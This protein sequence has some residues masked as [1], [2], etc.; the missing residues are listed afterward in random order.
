MLEGRTSLDDARPS[1]PAFGCQTDHTRSRLSEPASTT[2]ACHATVCMPALM[3]RDAG[4]ANSL[5]AWI[6]FTFQVPQCAHT[7]SSGRTQT[8]TTVIA[9]RSP[10]SSLMNTH[11]NG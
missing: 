1:G 8:T 6:D 3:D 7:S 4:A 2:C 10:M 5:A 11:L 9:E